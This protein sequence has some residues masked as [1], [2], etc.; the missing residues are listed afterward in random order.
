[1]SAWLAWFAAFVIPWQIFMRIHDIP[2]NRSHFAKL[3][4]NL[5]WI[6]RHVAG[7]LADPTTWGI[8]WPLCFAIIVLAIPFWWR[9]DWR[10]LAAL[11]VPNLLLTGGAFVTHYRAGISGSVAATAP[12]LYLHLAPATA[13]LAAVAAMTA[14][15]GLRAT[16]LEGV[17]VHGPGHDEAAG[18]SDHG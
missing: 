4:L 10:N 15:Q 18:G 16:R 7:Q 2:L 1:V 14:W 5:W 6:V 3:Y 13:A 8:F 12:R 11:V 17:E 9:T